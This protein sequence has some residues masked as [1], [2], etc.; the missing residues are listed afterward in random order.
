MFNRIQKGMY[1]DRAWKLVEGCTPVSEGCAHCWSATETHMRAKH[2]NAD[3][4]KRN[5]GLTLSPL[6][7]RERAEGEGR[8]CSFNGQVR[9]RR[10]NLSLPETVKKPTA[11]AIWNDLFHE[12]VPESFLTAAFVTMARNRQHTFFVLTKRAERMRDVLCAWVKSGLTLREGKGIRLP[13]V[14]IGVTAENQAQADKRIPILLQTP[15]AKRYVS[16]EPMLGPVNSSPECYMREPDEEYDDAP[17]GCKPCPCGKHWIN[18]FSSYSTECLD[19]VICGGESGTGARPM[20]PDWARSLRDQCQAA[21][22]PYFFKQWGEWLS[23]ESEIVGV[24]DNSSTK[25]GTDLMFRIGKTAAGRLLDG[26][27]YLEVPKI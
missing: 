14:W 22:V 17:V 6:P 25:I 27:A 5:K 12:D 16:I 21:G 24:S 13:N 1:W 2:P 15:A 7:S 4:A 26:K 9:L 20:H 3:I 18:M 10:D 8:S 23:A 19:W 11:F